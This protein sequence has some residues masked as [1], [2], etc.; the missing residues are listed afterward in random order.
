MGPN[1]EYMGASRG[2]KQVDSIRMRTVPVPRKSYE[3]RTQI[4]AAYVAPVAPHQSLIQKPGVAIADCQFQTT[5]PMLNLDNFVQIKSIRCAGNTVTIAFDGDASAA[6]AQAEWTTHAT[7]TNLAVMIGAEWKCGGKDATAFRHVQAVDMT[8]GTLV[9]TTEEATSDE[10]VQDY[11][12]EVNQYDDVAGEQELR[13][14]GLFNWSKSKVWPWSLYVNY[15]KATEQPAKRDIALLTTPW[16]GAHCIDCYVK[17]EAALKIRVTGSVIVVKSYEIELSG[18]LKAN[19]DLLLSIYQTARTDLYRVPLW[20]LP[21]NPVAVPG[22]FS[23]GPELRL[24]AAVTYG[25]DEQLDV[26]TGF[27]LDLPLKWTMA[28]DKG[29][30]GKPKFTSSFEPAFNYHPV[31][32]SQDFSVRVAAHLIPEF[33]VTIAILSMTA[34]SLDFG[35][36]NALGVQLSRGKYADLRCPD[37]VGIGLL[38]YR[39]HDVD[40]AVRSPI[41]NKKY[42]LWSSGRRALP[43]PNNAC[44]RC[45]GGSKKNA[46]AALLP[47]AA[48]ETTT[49]STALLST[50]SASSTATTTATT[51]S[52]LSTATAS[53][54]AT[55]SISTPDLPSTTATPTLSRAANTSTAPTPIG[56]ATVSPSTT[57]QTMTRISTDPHVKVVLPVHETI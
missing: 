49:S 40:F 28:S 15:D 1:G 50:T 52:G 11:A 3:P 46:T 45:I 38:L 9:L 34:F 8:H 29:L 20:A 51:T 14:R 24:I 23:L 56:S 55:A 5:K 30:F 57:T 6:K 12:I 48:M 41:L 37:G 25:S 17:G 19:L 44:N 47:A 53:A 26:T 31:T 13:K 27:D 16:A 2:A 32:A 18:D 4:K 35:V 7:S 54:V 22:V 33:G 42:T 39:Q 36:D 43:C 21:L 10:L